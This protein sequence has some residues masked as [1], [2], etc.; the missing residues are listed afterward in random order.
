MLV[1]PRPVIRAALESGWPVGL[2]PSDIGYYPNAA[3]HAVERPEGC[4]ELILILCVK[5]VGWAKLRGREYRIRAGQ[6][7]VIAPGEIHA[8]GASEEDPWSIYWCHGAGDLARSFAS[9]LK[10]ESDSPVLAVRDVGKLTAIFEEA[11]AELSH[12]YGLAQLQRASGALVH[13]LGHLGAQARRPPTE[14]TDVDERMEAVLHYLRQNLHGRVKL[15]ELA[16]Q[17]SLSM[18]HFCAV[19]KA[20]T[21]FPPLDFYLRLRVQRACELL[22]TTRLPIKQVS[23]EVGFGDP[24]Y[25]SRVFRRV[26]GVAP[27]EYRRSMR[28]PEV[29]GDVGM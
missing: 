24:L 29:G 21:G 20:R 14:G 9:I 3:G 22:A 25:F 6:L 18:S 4:G 28:A 23:A 27:M 7:L 17:C 12:G 2:F 26:Q 16:R 13:L 10:S 5:G 1:V 19:F 15:P 8:Y 11:I